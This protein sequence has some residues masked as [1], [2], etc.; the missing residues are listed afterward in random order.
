MASLPGPFP[1]QVAWSDVKSGRPMLA[2]L[3]YL[4]SLDAAVRAFFGT[5]SASNTAGAPMIGPLVNAA[6]DG[7]AAA[8]GVPVNGLYRN[9]SAVQVRVV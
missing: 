6:N 2:F 8:A 4:S 3:Q 9:G 5:A 7:A 1:S